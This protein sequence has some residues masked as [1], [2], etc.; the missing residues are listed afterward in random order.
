MSCVRPGHYFS[1][2]AAHAC[3]IVLLNREKRPEGFPDPAKPQS[4]VYVEG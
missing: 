1:H 3:E 2:V 4:G